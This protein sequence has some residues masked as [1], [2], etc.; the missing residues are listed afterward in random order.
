MPT[1]SR[2]AIPDRV[3]PA[4]R[5][6][7][8]LLFITGGANHFRSP[9][10]YRRIIP[11]QFPNPPLLVA[12]SGVC[13]IAGGLGLLIARLRRAAGWGLIALL[14]AVFPANLYMALHP[15]RFP[16]LHLPRWAFR[17]RLPLQPVLAAWVWLVARDRTAAANEMST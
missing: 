7:A 14:V 4:L 11:P 17:A 12:V 10:F 8:A 3:R 1:S 16:D 15:E 13:E 5:L 2:L 9:G 6:A